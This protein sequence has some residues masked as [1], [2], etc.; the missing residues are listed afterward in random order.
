MALN[1]R[2]VTAYDGKL[3]ETDL[4]NFPYGKARN[5]TTSGDGTGTPWD[6]QGINEMFAFQQGLLTLAQIVPDGTPDTAVDSQYLDSLVGMQ[7]ASHI[8]YRRNAIVYRQGTQRRAYRAI[9][10]NVNV[11]PEGVGQTDWAYE[12]FL[13]VV[14]NSQLSPITGVGN[15]T[16]FRSGN[17]VT[18][19]LVSTSTVASQTTGAVIVT[20]PTGFRPVTGALQTEF[21]TNVVASTG[22]NMST[23]ILNTSTLTVGDWSRPTATYRSSGSW[24]TSDL[25]PDI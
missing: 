10:D 5:V 9:N 17:I 16:F 6:A 19:R 15:V 22:T 4:G 11:D 25:L 7:W 21:L 2:N 23:A 3:D 12:P 1:L 20:I 8:N 13:S 24:P 14:S 18:F